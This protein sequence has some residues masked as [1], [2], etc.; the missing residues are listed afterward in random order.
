MV[1]CKTS[2]NTDVDDKDVVKAFS[3]A[4]GLVPPDCEN[5]VTGSQNQA[6]TDSL[7]ALSGCLD[8]MNRDRDASPDDKEKD[9]Q[10]CDD[11]AAT[12]KQT[13]SRLVAANAGNDQVDNAVETL[14]ARPVPV[15]KPPPPPGA[16]ELCR[17]LKDLGSRFPDNISL[18]EFQKIFAPGGMLDKH[19][20]ASSK[21]NPPY[22]AFFANA[23]DIQRDLYPDGKS[24]GLHY[25]IAAV[26][27]PG[28]SF[29]L[30]IGSQNL[31]SFGAP[32]ALVWTGSPQEKVTLEVPGFPTAAE[33]GSFAIFKFV[34]DVGK[35]NS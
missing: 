14:L 3:A 1:L 9:R 25:T 27:S 26:P 33:D 15:F 22:V 24:L 16:E 12:A 29:K 11:S 21:A 23:K 17:A 4:R 32:K 20:P 13:I 28:V 10:N 7:F 6:Y 30:T 2:K 31:D 19:Q 34:V 8:K 35:R 5:K 18:D